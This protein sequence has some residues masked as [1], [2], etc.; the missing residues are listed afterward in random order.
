MT[1]T[2]QG[3]DLSEITFWAISQLLMAKM[4]L[5]FNTKKLGSEPFN[6]CKNYLG[7]FERATYANAIRWP[8]L[9]K[10]MSLIITFELKHLG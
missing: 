6:K 1:L 3:H 4:L 10:K 8:P 2:F 5:K 9:C 7:R